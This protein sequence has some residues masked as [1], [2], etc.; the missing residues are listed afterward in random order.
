MPERTGSD[1]ARAAERP[2]VHLARRLAARCVQLGLTRQE[3][4][5]RAGMAST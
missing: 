4:S 3:M 2:L 1:T 5:V